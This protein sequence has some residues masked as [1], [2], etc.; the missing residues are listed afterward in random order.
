MP[1]IAPTAMIRPRNANKSTIALNG[2]VQNIKTNPKGNS[3]IRFRLIIVTPNNHSTPMKHNEDINAFKTP[4]QSN[5]G[6]RIVGSKSKIIKE[7]LLPANRRVDTTI[8]AMFAIFSDDFLGDCWLS[9]IKH[10]TF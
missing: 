5:S 9:I 3:K 2:I 4:P 1:A 10:L 8:N 7:T 6:G